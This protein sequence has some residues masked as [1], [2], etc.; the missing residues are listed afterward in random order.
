[1]T[2]RP[3]HLRLLLLAAW[4]P[5]FRALDADSDRN[6]ARLENL[7]AYVESLQARVTAKR[8]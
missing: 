4:G 7:V 1:M 8:D 5:I 6:K 3:I 2:F